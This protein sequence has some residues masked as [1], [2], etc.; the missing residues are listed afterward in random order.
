[1]IYAVQLAF[2][3]S[4]NKRYVVGDDWL[5]ARSKKPIYYYD[6][7]KQIGQI[8]LLAVRWETSELVEYSNG[9]LPY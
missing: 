4:G 6:L 7:C 5:L 1:V 2:Y 8:Y 3:F 9:K